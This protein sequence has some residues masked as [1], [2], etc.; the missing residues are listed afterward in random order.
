VNEREYEVRGLEVRDLDLLRDTI[1]GAP[2]ME[3]WVS[4]R[5]TT[6]EGYTQVS[7]DRTDLVKG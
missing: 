1:A 3:E 6:E 2:V 4:R 7:G 5:G